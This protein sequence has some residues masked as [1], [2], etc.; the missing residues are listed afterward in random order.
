MLDD[1]STYEK[2][3]EFVAHTFVTV[4]AA[5]SASAGGASGTSST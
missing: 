2:Q 1:I 5:C 3:K 4:I